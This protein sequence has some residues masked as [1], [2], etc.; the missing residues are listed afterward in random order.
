MFALQSIGA[1][2]VAF[3]IDAAVFLY[4]GT[5][6]QSMWGWFIVPIFDVAGLSFMIATGLVIIASFLTMKITIPETKQS[7]GE[8]IT[9]ELHNAYIKGLKISFFWFMAWIAVTVL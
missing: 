6:F 3:F 5:V 1:L 7:M 9:E 4:A 8:I 2:V